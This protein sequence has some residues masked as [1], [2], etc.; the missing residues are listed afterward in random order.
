PRSIPSPM[1]GLVSDDVLQG[2]C[3]HWAFHRM[4]TVSKRR[5]VRKIEVIADDTYRPRWIAQI[6]C[7]TVEPPIHMARGARSLPQTGGVVRIVKVGT[8]GFDD[9]RRRIEE[10]ARVHN[11]MGGGVDRADTPIESVIDVKASTIFIEGEAG[12]PRSRVNCR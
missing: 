12:R 7:Q 11:H 4:K 8:A 2:Q 3:H 1:K 5:H 9:F 6:P 10:R